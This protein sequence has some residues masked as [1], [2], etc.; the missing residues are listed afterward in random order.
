MLKNKQNRGQELEQRVVESELTDDAFKRLQDNVK[1]RDEAIKELIS[2][3]EQEEQQKKKQA[4]ESGM[5]VDEYD[6]LHEGLKVNEDRV[7]KLTSDQKNEQ[8]RAQQLEQHFKKSR[9]LEDEYKILK[10]EEIKGL[11]KRKSG[12]KSQEYL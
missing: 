3:L 10:D 6:K 4:E 11:K 8:I 9:M 5:L 2:K 7:K 12:L 1:K